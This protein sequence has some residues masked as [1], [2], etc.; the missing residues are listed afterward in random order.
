MH[1]PQGFIAT[2]SEAEAKISSADVLFSS[3][4]ARRFLKLLFITTELL[5]F[6]TLLLFF[7]LLLIFITVM[8]LLLSFLEGHLDLD[9]LLKHQ[10]ASL[11]LNCLL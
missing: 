6:N 8:L 1:D 10:T 7:L 11:P 4:R 5:L 3:F 9:V 2:C